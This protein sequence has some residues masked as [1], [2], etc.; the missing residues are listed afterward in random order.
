MSSLPHG[1]LLLCSPGIFFQ[2]HVQLQFLV[3]ACLTASWLL[4][5]LRE[6]KN[7]SR[8]AVKDPCRMAS[9]ARPR[10]LK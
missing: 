1:D 6:A 10:K 2:L 3:T 9:L 8:K 5:C 7:S 4:S